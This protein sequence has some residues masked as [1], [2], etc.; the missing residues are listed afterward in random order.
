MNES[1]F[2]EA[3][4]V[5]KEKGEGAKVEKLN[6]ILESLLVSA[7]HTGTLD[8]TP[9][10]VGAFLAT[11][12]DEMGTIRVLEATKLYTYLPDL[13]RPDVGQQL[14]GKRQV[15]LQATNLLDPDDGPVDV[16]ATLDLPRLVEI[17]NYYHQKVDAS[18]LTQTPVYQS[19]QRILT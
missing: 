5:L 12:N 15:E 4:T 10:F 16:V 14:I 19:L 7:A 1:L 11:P 2:A 8:M 17:G 18:D 13:K 9:F 3:H 6:Q